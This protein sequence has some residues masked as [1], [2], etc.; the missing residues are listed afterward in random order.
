MQVLVDLADDREGYRL[1][2]AAAEWQSD[3]CTEPWS[4]GVRGCT[5]LGEQLVGERR[6]H[7][8]TNVADGS[9]GERA[10]VGKIR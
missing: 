8:Q 2:G 5:E 7:Q 3:R 6:G 4:Y 9:R 10:Q 1:R